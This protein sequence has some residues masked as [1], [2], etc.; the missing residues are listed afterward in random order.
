MSIT[1]NIPSGAGLPLSTTPDKNGPDA[2]RKVAREMESVFAY[3]MI[4]AMH[5]TTGLFS[6]N[7]F[8]G[9]AFMTLF[10]MELSKIMS[11]RGLGLQDMLIKAFDKTSAPAGNNTIAPDALSAPAT[12]RENVLEREREIILPAASEAA[13]SSD[14]GQRRDPFTGEI[15][16]HYGLDIAAPENSEIHP[17]RSGKVAF[18]GEEKGYGNVVI[19][20]HGNGLVTKYAHNMVNCVKQGDVVDPATVIARVG[21]TGRSTGPHVHIEAEYNGEKVDPATLAAQG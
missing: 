4:K 1:N 20:D 17:V 5:Q 3:E 15:K 18:S 7:S 21:S 14:F 13:I 16:F 2:I 19:I 6:N 11:E 12:G 9:G 10:D 8:G